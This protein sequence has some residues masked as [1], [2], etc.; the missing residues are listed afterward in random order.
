MNA[1]VPMQQFN[2][3]LKTS[4]ASFSD[5]SIFNFEINVGNN[6]RTESVLDK[7]STKTRNIVL[8]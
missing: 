2:N 1:K 7:C 4:I 6:N 3:W 5:L 8:K